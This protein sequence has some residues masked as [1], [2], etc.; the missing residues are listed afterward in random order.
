[1]NHEEFKIYV[2][3]ETRDLLALAKKAHSAVA[4]PMFRDANHFHYWYYLK[5]GE[6]LVSLVQF[7]TIIRAVN[8]LWDPGI[9]SQEEKRLTFFDCGFT[10]DGQL[11]YKEDQK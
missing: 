5:D 1:M 6:A 7:K 4:V 9:F 3:E 2:I 8:S 11:I 10:L